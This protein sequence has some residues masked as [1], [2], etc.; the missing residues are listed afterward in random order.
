MEVEKSSIY[1]MHSVHLFGYFLGST[2][3]L[4][5]LSLLRMYNLHGRAWK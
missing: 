3:L 1:H 2:L 4:N 5:V